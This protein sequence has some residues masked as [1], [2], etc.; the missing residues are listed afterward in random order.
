MALQGSTNPIPQ[1]KNLPVLRDC[2]VLQKNRVGII[3]FSYEFDRHLQRIGMA[4]VLFVAIL[5]LGLF[6][7]FPALA[8]IARALGDLLPRDLLI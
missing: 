7:D 5:L 8:G 2:S 3:Q 4:T 1:P 6:L